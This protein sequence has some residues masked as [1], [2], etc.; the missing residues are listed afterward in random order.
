MSFKSFTFKA[1]PVITESLLLNTADTQNVLLANANP[2]QNIN[3]DLL[4]QVLS[5]NDLYNLNLG[6]VELNA[7]YDTSAL[8]A[9]TDI[10]HVDTTHT[11][12][13]RHFNL[14]NDIRNKVEQTNDETGLHKRL[15][16]FIEKWKD[17]ADVQKF[18]T[19]Y[20]SN[21]NNTVTI[22]RQSPALLESQVKKTTD[23]ES[24]ALFN[25]SKFAM[26]DFHR[27]STLR[28]DFTRL[29]RAKSLEFRSSLKTRSRLNAEIEDA[30]EDFENSEKTLI[31]A[32]ENY[33]LVRGLLEEQLQAVDDA[34]VERQR[35]LSNPTGLC[36]VRI[37]DLPMQIKFH[38]TP[39]IAESK[40]GQ[41]PV[42]CRQAAALPER[43]LPFLDLLDDQPMSSWL[44]LKKYWRWLPK[45]WPQKPPVRIIPQLSQ[46]ISLMP[47]PFHTLINAVT[48]VQS[49]QVAVT[50][51][52]SL[53]AQN[54]RRA[55]EV[56]LEQLTKARHS[57]LR[58]KARR[59]QEDLSSALSCL[60]QQLQE[61]SPSARFEWSRLAENDV[62]NTENPLSWPDF[63]E[64]A[65]QM[66]GLYVREIIE[67]LYLQLDRNAM[68]E[69]RSAMRTAIRACLL[70]SVNDDPDDLLHGKVIQFPG[71]INPGVLMTASLNRIPFLTERLKVYDGNRQL[72]A[73][74]QVVDSNDTEANIEIISTYIT[75][76]V[77]F[78]AWTVVGHKALLDADFD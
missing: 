55:D 41:L 56:T 76:P 47:L 57:G 20:Y 71:F 16:D 65:S 72:I 64:Y 50:S 8:V 4:S 45:V 6:S 2:I 22:T 53:S 75:T 24:S 59:L 19:R 52:V 77:A 63:H 29:K 42:I 17:D 73:E 36:F 10:S 67:W 43:L 61:I 54:Q 40:P 60:L 9:D 23:N 51:H 35:I 5:N 1:Q 78:S 74:A 14:F 62:L 66:V 68:T 11:L 13:N 33:A 25:L 34:F 18:L 32:E 31:E 69:S 26:N 28:R 15:K 58:N 70:Q 30:R 21:T 38:Q 37:N 7:V 12:F 48:A 27:M 49:R 39:L 44:K 46:N 3:P